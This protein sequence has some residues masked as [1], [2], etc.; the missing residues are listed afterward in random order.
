MREYDDH[1][2]LY[3]PVLQR[4]IILVAVIVAVPVVLWTI[5]AFVRTYVAAPKAPT[6]QHVAMT[7]NGDSAA[8]ASDANQAPAAPPQPAQTPAP[9]A[10]VAEAGATASDARNPLLE[11]KKPTASG[12]PQSSG[13]SALPAVPQ[14]AVATAAQPA[15]PPPAVQPIAAPPTAA[16]PAPVMPSKTMP[17]VA[18]KTDRAAAPAAADRSIV[19]PD[20]SAN[21]PTPNGAATTVAPATPPAAAASDDA[22]ALPAAAALTGPVPLPRRRP[23]LYAMAQMATA[24]PLPRARPAAAPAPTPDTMND[25]APG[26]FDPGMGGGRY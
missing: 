7:A 8:A 16:P 5:T 13:A 1:I 17:S 2:R 10:Q 18:E 4:I 14:A 23:A 21:L 11:I 25:A 24:V 9:A 26:G 3:T 20:P 19:W 22:D 6:F 15:A 12:Q